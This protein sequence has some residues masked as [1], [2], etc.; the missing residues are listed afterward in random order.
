MKPI[1]IALLIYVLLNGYVTKRLNKSYYINEEMRSLHK[2]FIWF[3]P[4]L[5][6]LI[7][8]N[9][10]KKPKTNNVQTNTKTQRDKNT[11]YDGFYESGQGV[12]Y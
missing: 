2:K 11:K 4:F 12:D 10:W 3:L 7:I 5:G 1:L 9:F 6:P 8:K